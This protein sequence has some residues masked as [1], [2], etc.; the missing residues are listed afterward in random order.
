VAEPPE[1]AGTNPNLHVHGAVG[2]AEGSQAAEPLHPPPIESPQHID[3]LLLRMRA[4]DREAAAEFLMRYGSRI[5]RR[6]RGKLGSSMRRLFD[7]L[8]ILSTLGRRLDVFIM[9]GQL[10]ATSEDQLWALLFKMAD[11]AVVDKTRIFQQLRSVE[12]E[13]GEFARQLAQ[14][15]DRAESQSEFGADLEIEKCLRALHKIVDR[16]ILSAWLTGQSYEAIA[17]QL[18]MS[19]HTVRKRWERIKSYLKDTFLTEDA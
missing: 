5:R 16:Q 9:S 2:L 10:K 13:D 15:M 8:D 17:D 7:S 11:H 1:T 19:T 3:A 14:R 12:G 18:G 6:I 4:G